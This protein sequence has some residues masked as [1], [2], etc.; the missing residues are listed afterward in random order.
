[1]AASSNDAGHSKYKTAAHLHRT[2]DS[3]WKEQIINHVQ[4]CQTNYQ[5]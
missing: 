2:F 3:S 4:K 1:M 5:T